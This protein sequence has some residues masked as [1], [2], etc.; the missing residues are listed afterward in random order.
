MSLETEATLVCDIDNFETLYQV[1]FTRSEFLES[2]VIVVKSIGNAAESELPQK[3]PQ[4][5]HLRSLTVEASRNSNFMN[6]NNRKSFPVCFIKKLSTIFPYV[7][8]L[9]IGQY[10]FFTEIDIVL[11]CFRSLKSL[12]IYN[13]HRDGEYN[14]R[15]VF[16]HPNLTMLKIKSISVSLQ[17]LKVFRCCI[18][19]EELWLAGSQDAESVGQILPAFQSLKS[20]HLKETRFSSKMRETVKLRSRRVELINFLECKCKIDRQLM[21]EHA[22][23][24]FNKINLKGG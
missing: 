18:N 16:V 17:Y 7:E 2:L 22:A 12:V 13:Y 9:Q 3:L 15:G 5:I 10:F 11:R 4:M 19:L 21:V 1:L 8:S 24:E 20:L 6:A 14:P 23:N